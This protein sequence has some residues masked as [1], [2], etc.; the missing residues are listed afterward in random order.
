MDLIKNGVFLCQLR[1]SK[2]M[3]QKEVAKKVGVVPKTVSKWETGNGF[4]DV[5]TLSILADLFEVS[6]RSLLNGCVVKNAQE[7]GNMKRIKFYACPCCGSFLQSMGQA[8][9]ECCG[10]TLSALNA[11]E[12]DQEHLISCSEVDGELYLQIDHPMQK[13]H[14]ISFV[15]YVNLDRVITIKLYPEQDCAVRIPKVYGGKIAYY[16]TNHG[17]FEY[18]IKIPR[19]G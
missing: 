10:K 8:Q 12:V 9:I 7:V 14:L 18:Q 6:E 2:G 3:T 15:S 13:N 16:C 19:K 17:L 4:P 5:S 1:K 11:Q